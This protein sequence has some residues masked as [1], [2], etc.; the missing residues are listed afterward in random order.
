MSQQINAAAIDEIIFREQPYAA[1]DSVEAEQLAEEFFEHH[2]AGCPGFAAA[3][4]RQ[5]NVRANC[6]ET[7]PLIPTSVF[8]HSQLVSISP[9]AIDKWCL[10]SGTRG[11]ES[12]IGRDQLTLDRLLGSFRAALGLI[13]E[14]FE[15]ELDIV[16]LGPS[17]EAAGDIWFPYVM[18]LAELIFPATPCFVDGKLDHRLARETVEDT[19]AQGRHVGLIGAPYAILEFCEGLAQPMPVNQAITVVS[20]GGWKRM[21]GQRL[22]QADFDAKVCAA[23]GL[24]DPQRVRDAFNQVELNTVIAECRLRR[25]HIPPWVYACTRDPAD[26]S[27]RLPGEPGLVSFVDM[28]AFSYPAII[29]GDD[30]GIV[31]SLPC[32]CGEPGNTLEILGRVQ[33]PGERGCALVLEQRGTRA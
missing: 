2:L 32:P 29:V 4:E 27:A 18:S 12:R 9:A 28:S 7:Y 5:G 23:L 8:K 17:H 20:A 19:L 31:H 15:D 3:V 6:P 10:S 26:L 24:D 21:D 13:G 16:H 33:R 11:V 1:L 25:K 22:V 14:W 30:V